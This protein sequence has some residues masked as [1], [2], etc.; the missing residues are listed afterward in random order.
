M[1]KFVTLRVDHNMKYGK[2]MYSS[3]QKL[4]TQTVF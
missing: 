1:K 4:Q 2:T 3:L